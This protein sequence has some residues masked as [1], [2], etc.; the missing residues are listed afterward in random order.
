MINIGGGM[1]MKLILVRHG[2]SEWNALNLFTGWE[3]V[4]LS[5]VGIDEAVSLGH[6][7]KASNINIDVV[8][9]SLLKR[10]IH[11]AYYVMNCLDRNWV[12]VIKDWRLNERHYG[13]L[14]GLNKEETALKYGDEQVHIWRR[15]YDVRPPL[16]E[17]SDPHAPHNQ[18]MYQ[19]LLDTVSL[20]LHESLADTKL[21]TL[22]CFN[23]VIKNQLFSGKDVLIAA[24][25][26]SL[27]SLIMDL[28]GLN[29]D[30]VVALEL[31]T[32]VAVV[33]ELDKD[34]KIMSKSFI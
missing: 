32:G 13:A 21:R 18:A 30:E 2:Q 1:I 27:R 24:H 10:A 23:A 22:E 5:Q 16:M 26:N 8:Y 15:S 20:P 33:Y 7:L 3:D 28:E 6:R 34:M 29:K 12:E 4:S 17:A 9:T 14:Q 31:Q 19:S 11:T 25:G